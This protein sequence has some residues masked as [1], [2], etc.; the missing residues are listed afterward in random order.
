[1]SKNLSPLQS[2]K[3]TCTIPMLLLSIATD[4]SPLAQAHSPQASSISHTANTSNQ[5]FPDNGAPKG[6]RRGGTSRQD[7]CPSLN[8]PITAIVPGEETHKTS[9]LGATVSEYPT[10]WV[11]IPEFPTNVRFAE[12]VFQDEQGNDIWRTPMTLPKKQSLIAIRLPQH[13]QYALQQNRT[14][15]WFFKVY[16]GEPQNKPNYI[17]VD[18]WLKRVA[19]SPHL[20]QQLKAAKPKEYT[21]S[22]AHNL[23]YD[24]ITNLAELNRSGSSQLVAQDWINAFK[25]IGLEELAGAPIVQIESL[26]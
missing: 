10:F 11:Y 1:M 24:A 17:Y 4:P 15:H 13:P 12:F 16:C 25:E 8:T 14:Y 20:Q 3:L 2:V 21:V 26:K 23:W 7:G 5:Q 9:F 22:L 18:A 6:R 19:L